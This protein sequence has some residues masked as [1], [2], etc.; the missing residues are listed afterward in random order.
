[1]DHPQDIPRQKPCI[2]YYKCIHCDHWYEAEGVCEGNC[3][4]AQDR[5]PECQK[6]Q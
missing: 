2:S 3:F 4:T 1:M 6:E 5:C